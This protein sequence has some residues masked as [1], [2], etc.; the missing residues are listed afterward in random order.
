M[1]DA[2][3]NERYTE[4]RFTLQVENRHHLARVMQ[5]LRSLETVVHIQR[6][7]G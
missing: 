3:G 1:D 7:K 6:L 2:T 4:I 5:A